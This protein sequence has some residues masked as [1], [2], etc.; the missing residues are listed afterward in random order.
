MTRTGRPSRWLR[1]KPRW[2][3]GGGRGHNAAIGPDSLAR[4]LDSYRF[5]ARDVL[6]TP[7]QSTSPARRAESDQRGL[8]S[9]LYRRTCPRTVASLSVTAAVGAWSRLPSTLR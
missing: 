8:R 1:A 7:S 3:G 2:V 9:L 5:H 4:Q 6:R